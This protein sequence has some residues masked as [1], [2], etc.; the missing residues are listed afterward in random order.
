[1]MGNPTETAFRFFRVLVSRQAHLNLLYLLAAFPLGV[2]YFAFLVS[3]LSAGISLSIIW[4]GIPIL[5]VVGF[6]WWV[7]ASL[8]RFLAIH[9]LKEDVPTMA[10]PSS[11]G[12]DIWTRVKDWCTNPVTWK[13]PLYLLLKFPLGIATFVILTVLISSTLAFLSMP[14]TFELLPQ[15]QMGAFFEPGLPAWHIDGMNDALLAALVGLMLW[16]VTLHV[17]NGLAWVHAKL[18]KVMLSAEP[19][20]GFT[21]LLSAG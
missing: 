15:V 9:W 18:A 14:L 16:P 20:G 12:K 8:E 19:T 13:S 21:A 6:G 3:G 4:V 7:L 2:F 17:A 10:R 11:E 1:M 5:L